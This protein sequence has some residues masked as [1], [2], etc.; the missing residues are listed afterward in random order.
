MR[1]INSSAIDHVVG[2]HYECVAA[3]NVELHWQIADCIG[4]DNDAGGHDDDDAVCLKHTQPLRDNKHLSIVE[5][6]CIE[7][8]HHHHPM[9]RRCI[10]LQL[11]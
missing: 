8:I 4:V 3:D 9:F 2:V 7:T 1:T 10:A 6:Y 11:I 5:D